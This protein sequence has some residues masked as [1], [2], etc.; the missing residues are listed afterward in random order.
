[1]DSEEYLAIPYILTMESV[2][3]PDGEWVRRASYP[4]LPG[5]VAE[6]FS[7]LDAIEQLEV[8]RRQLILERLQRGESV[9]VPRPPLRS[10]TPA[11]SQE[12]REFARWLVQQ[13]RLSETDAPPDA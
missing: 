2:E 4:E 9:P 8:L 12:R 5:A 7:P 1:V 6:A 11:L 3:R 13:N 10:A